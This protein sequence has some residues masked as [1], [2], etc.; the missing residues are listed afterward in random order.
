M[1]KTM[2]MT[3]LDTDLGPQRIDQL[4]QSVPV[5]R[6]IKLASEKWSIWIIPIISIHQIAPEK[7]PGRFTHE[8]NA[9][10]TSLR[11]TSFSRTNT[12]PALLHVYIF[13][14]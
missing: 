13:D 12:D 1:P 5:E 4:A 14:S 8:D 3:L 6:P 2:R 7:A 11:F 9:T 10:F